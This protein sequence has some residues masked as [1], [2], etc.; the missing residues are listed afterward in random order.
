MRKRKCFHE[1][2]YKCGIFS[3]V[4]AIKSGGRMTEILSV[5]L[6]KTDTQGPDGLTEFTT[7]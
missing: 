7:M 1:N 3:L 2:I 5:G 6:Q 4:F